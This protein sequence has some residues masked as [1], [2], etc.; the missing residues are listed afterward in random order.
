MSLRKIIKEAINEDLNNPLAMVMNI[1]K[2]F[3]LDYLKESGGDPQSTYAT[4]LLKYHNIP[5]QTG[6]LYFFDE[7]IRENENLDLDNATPE[8][9]K[10]PQLKRYKVSFEVPV[11][12]YSTEYWEL[13]SFGYSVKN[14][15]YRVGDD[16]NYWDGKM[17]D[18]YTD[19]G[20]TDDEY[21]V[22]SITEID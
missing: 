20:E 10:I 12:N 16:V 1:D 3:L 18:K 2:E 9:I 7:L 4:Q 8:D 22:T 14:I 11:R 19:E 13:E 6:T 21:E 5:V 15:E 17:V